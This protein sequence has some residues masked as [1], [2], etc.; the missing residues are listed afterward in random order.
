MRSFLGRRC[1]QHGGGGVVDAGSGGQ[2]G[3][4]RGRCHL[5]HI[6]D[7]GLS[8]PDLFRQ[9]LQ[10]L[11]HL[12]IE[13]GLRLSAFVCLCLLLL[14]SREKL[15]HQGGEVCCLFPHG[16]EELP[17]L[18]G[19]L[20]RRRGTR[21]NRSNPAVDFVGSHRSE[22]PP[23]AVD[24]TDQSKEL[25]MPRRKEI[26]GKKLLALITNCD[27]RSLEIGDTGRNLGEEEIATE[28]R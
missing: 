6:I 18:D 28:E 9:T 3:R 8:D 4:G 1:V 23:T 26:W 17:G 15:L 2:S 12:L 20:G 10:L 11:R 5:P 22:F 16:S 24:V 13:L 21:P 25:R 19:R 7:P 14:E 27:D